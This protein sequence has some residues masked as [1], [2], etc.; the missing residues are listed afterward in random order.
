[1]ADKELNPRA[2]DFI[3]SAQAMED[4]DDGAQRIT[5]TASSDQVDL[6]VDRFAMSALRKMEQQFPGMAIFLNHE[7]HVPEDVFGY[8]RKASII[9]RNGRNDLDLEIEVAKDNKRALETYG[10]IKSGVRLGVSVGVL[11]LAAAFSD[12]KVDGNRVFVIDDVKT[13][14]ASIVGIPANR[15]SWVHGALKAASAVLAGEDREYV[16]KYLSGLLTADGGATVA[17]VKT[18]D[19][20][21][22]DPETTEATSAQVDPVTGAPINEDEDFLATLATPVL[23]ASVR[24]FLAAKG[25]TPD[26][27]RKW[28]DIV[29]KSA[30]AGNE[31]DEAK[32]YI[33]DV[34]GSSWYGGVDAKT[35]TEELDQ[36]KASRIALH[37]NSPGGAITD[38]VAIR[39]A[40]ANHP[41]VVTAYVDGF[42]ASS[43]SFIALNSD[44]VVMSEG[45]MMMIHEPWSIAMGDAKAFHKE[46]E[47]LDKFAGII[48]RMY[49]AKAGGTEDEW[50][51]VMREE[52]WYTDQEAVDAK[53]ADSV[54]AAKKKPVDPAEPDED[55]PKKKFFTGAVLVKKAPAAFTAKFARPVEPAVAASQDEQNEV[56]TDLTT[57]VSQLTTALKQAS[58][59]NIDLMKERNEA[60]AE[61]ETLNATHE[62][63]A[64]AL[65]E[66][67]EWVNRALDAPLPRKIAAEPQFEDFSA[68]Y[69]NL[70]A[71]IVAQ[72][73]R[74]AAETEAHN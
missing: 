45:A 67:T 31:D 33:Y 4:G 46:A 21:T 49:A 56:I 62:D 55:D 64:A 50:R 18:K 6:S 27:D 38:A 72:M 42:A 23:D 34:I 53:L 73:A 10:M 3:F 63:T 43:A 41:A 60:K 66:M 20:T 22:T 12:E 71:R 28:F 48:A 2:F 61:L 24:A 1:M 32:V 15:D 40:L 39:N 51:D 44:K 7:Y 70:D 19:A 36:I 59:A 65:M 11:V 47:V 30:E 74:K 57:S 25:H 8:V 68:K 52:T 9:F 26:P 37:I 69:P 14:E 17:A 58:A 54:M 35:F 29:V 16:L 13:L 5:C